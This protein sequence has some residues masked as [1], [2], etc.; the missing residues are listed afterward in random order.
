MNE[1]QHKVLMVVITGV[2]GYVL[3]GMPVV[4]LSVFQRSTQKTKGGF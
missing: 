4:P 1:K 2:M 3:F